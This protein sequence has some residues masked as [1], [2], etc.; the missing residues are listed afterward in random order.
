MTAIIGIAIAF[1]LMYYAGPSI[2]SIA[3]YLFSLVLFS[4]CSVFLF[5]LCSVLLGRSILEAFSLNWF[6]RVLV[7][8]LSLGISSKSKK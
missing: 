7:R 4:C 6:G 3:W 2:A 8:I 1:G 5:A